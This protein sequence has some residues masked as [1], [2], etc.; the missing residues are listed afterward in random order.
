MPSTFIKILLSFTGISPALLLLYLYRIYHEFKHLSIYIKAGSLREIGAGVVNF[1]SI[2]YLLLLFVGFVL[3]AGKIM[4][5]AKT[6]FAVGRIS[7]KSIKS[8]DNNFGSVLTSLVPILIKFISPDLPDWVILV[9]FVG[10]GLVL[11]ITGKGSYNLNI[12][13]RVG[14]GYRHY[15]I[16]TKA[17]VTYLMLSKTQLINPKDISE[18]AQLT[19]HMIVK[20]P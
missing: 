3:V 7:A 16:A 6:R 1:L 10:F 13:L 14:F 8:A 15:E 2:H 5:L 20:I 11:A 18:Y 19:D 12:V 17:E 4:K 9:C